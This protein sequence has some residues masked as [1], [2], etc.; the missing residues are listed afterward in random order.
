MRIS[1]YRMLHRVLGPSRLVFGLVFGAMLAPSSQ[2]N[3]FQFYF[4]TYAKTLFKTA[5]IFLPK[6]L[7]FGVVFWSG[8]RCN[9]VS[10]SH[11]FHGATCKRFWADLGTIM[12]RF[13]ADF[14]TIW[15]VMGSILDRFQVVIV[16]HNY[17]KIY[18]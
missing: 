12:G 3:G 10:F 8:V 17:I 2:P 7:I 4:E 14:E 15:R 16:L 9:M 1:Q 18:K 11:L 13:W 5:S 6:S